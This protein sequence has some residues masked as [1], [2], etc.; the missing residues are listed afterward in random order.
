MGPQW[1]SPFFPT[2]HW[3][4]TTECACS[5]KKLRAGGEEEGRWARSIFTS[6]FFPV[7]DKTLL[8]SEDTPVNFQFRSI[9][10]EIRL[11]WHPLEIIPGFK[12]FHTLR[13][14]KNTLTTCFLCQPH[15]NIALDKSSASRLFTLLRE[16]RIVLPHNQR[17]Q[18]LL[19][20]SYI[21]SDSKSVCISCQNIRMGFPGVAEVPVLPADY[22]VCSPLSQG[23]NEPSKFFDSL[24][25][26]SPKLQVFFS[27]LQQQELQEILS[28]Q[29]SSAWFSNTSGN[30]FSHL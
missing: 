28:V 24:A 13:V 9:Y 5:A 1:L 30:S 4:C 26:R 22:Q 3:E 8:F 15:P 25:H 12:R 21:H 18:V 19:I 20:F 2:V 11:P 27:R 29:S 16:L 17:D 10:Q 6:L 7:A 23:A 14:P